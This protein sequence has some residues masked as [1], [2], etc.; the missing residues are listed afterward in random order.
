MYDEYSSGSIKD[1][2]NNVYVK[3]NTLYLERTHTEPAAGEFLT[4]DLGY[5]NQFVAVD[6]ASV[7]SIDKIC[8]RTNSAVSVK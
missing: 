2:L 5:W 6:K 7:E 4:E 3:G 1:T 8:V